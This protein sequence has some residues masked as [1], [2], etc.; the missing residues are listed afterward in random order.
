MVG[1]RPKLGHS[2]GDCLIHLLFTTAILLV[3]PKGYLEPYNQVGLQSPAQPISSIWVGWP[4]STLSNWQKPRTTH[5]MLITEILHIQFHRQFFITYSGFWLV[6]ILLRLF[7]ISSQKR[8]E[9]EKN[10]FLLIK[11]KK[12]LLRK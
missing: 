11:S 3:Q 8:N 1:P 4:R 9:K 6:N 5:L 2:L 7:D 12:K 10:T